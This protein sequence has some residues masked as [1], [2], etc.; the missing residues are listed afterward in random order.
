MLIAE[1]TLEVFDGIDTHPVR[2]VVQK[3]Q[4]TKFGDWACEYEI[5]WPEGPRKFA[6][7]GIDSV[8]A[9]II[10]L[11]M[12]GTELYTSNYHREGQL[13]HEGLPGGYGFPVASNC[14]D[15]LVGYDRDL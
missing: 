6:G 14:R 1:R 3:P 10:A 15:L 5:G 4:Q 2:I 11:Q 13:R 8:Q 12:I 9:L 7:H